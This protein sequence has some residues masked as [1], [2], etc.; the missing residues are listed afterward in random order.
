M[1]LFC[2]V[3]LQTDYSSSDNKSKQQQQSVSL[4]IGYCS[5]DGFFT[6]TPGMQ[7]AVQVAK[8]L[9]QKQGHEL[10]P[11]HIP[12]GEHAFKL[13]LD[14]IKADAM[15]QFRQLMYA[16]LYDSIIFFFLLTAISSN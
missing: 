4:R 7:R 10:V 16:R 8:T 5:T 6:P 14:L 15:H 1:Y 2:F 13:Y 3:Y 12:D 9:L 11:F